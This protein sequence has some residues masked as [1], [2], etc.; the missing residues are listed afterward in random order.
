MGGGEL[1]IKV[2]GAA[3]RMTDQDGQFVALVEAF[4]RLRR[5]RQ[6]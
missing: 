4:D 3:R 2:I 6:G 1:G 5:R